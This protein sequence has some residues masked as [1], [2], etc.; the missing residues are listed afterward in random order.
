[1]T[2]RITD[3]YFAFF[4]NS[5]L[6]K[7]QKIH[8]IMSVSSCWVTL[9]FLCLLKLRNVAWM[10]KC[11]S[12]HE[13]KA[14]LDLILLE[15]GLFT[16]KKFRLWGSTGDAHKNTSLQAAASLLELKAPVCLEDAVL[17]GTKGPPLPPPKHCQQWVCQC[18][19]CI[20]ETK[21]GAWMWHPGAEHAKRG[22]ALSEKYNSWL[23]VCCWK[24][25]PS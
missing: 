12:Q 14:Y 22:E 21:N 10:L 13:I 19:T 5:S 6:E 25:M 1:M 8:V 24:W 4:W 7:E 18:E 16:W 2:F 11:N 17:I 20:M 15:I 9:N 3:F 23:I